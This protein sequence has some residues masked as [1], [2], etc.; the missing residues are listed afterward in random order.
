MDTELYLV[1]NSSL[2]I[3][4][5]PRRRY[6]KQTFSNVP[7]VLDR[8]FKQGVTFFLQKNIKE[9]PI[10]VTKIYMEYEICKGDM[11]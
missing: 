2:Q 3:T 8:T 7:K 9:I 6:S 5:S 11:L 10:S 4:G 1:T